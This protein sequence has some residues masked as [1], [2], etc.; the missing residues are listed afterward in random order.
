MDFENHRCDYNVYTMEA[1]FIN[2]LKLIYKIQ[3][4]HFNL[5][6]SF[7][8]TFLTYYL[9]LWTQK[10]TVV[11][12]SSA[13]L[14][15]ISFNFMF[16]F[17]IIRLNRKLKIISRV[18]CWVKK[19][20]TRPNFSYVDVYIQHLVHVFS[21]ERSRAIMALLFMFEQFDRRCQNTFQY[22]M[23]IA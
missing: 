7:C 11:V 10:I 9:P 8:N 13:L 21:G 4:L 18:T 1:N 12:I 5:G 16:L 20:L 6:H 22:G 14:K 23:L 19:Q 3:R 15:Q 2:L 17:L